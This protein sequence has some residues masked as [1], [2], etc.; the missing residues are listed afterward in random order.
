MILFVA[1]LI[2]LYRIIIAMRA[3]LKMANGRRCCPSVLSIT[4]LAT[5]IRGSAAVQPFLLLGPAA[6]RYLVWACFRQTKT[7][8]TIFTLRRSIN[9]GTIKRSKKFFVIIWSKAPDISWVMSTIAQTKTTLYRI[10]R[11]MVS[12]LLIFDVSLTI[13]TS[14]WFVRIEAQL[15]MKTYHT[16]FSQISL[17][18]NAGRR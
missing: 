13:F 16:D 4:Y 17:F 3:F 10:G 12:E 1:T 2:I 15:I 11:V 5:V 18:V 6:K 9:D 8:L 7:M 14:L